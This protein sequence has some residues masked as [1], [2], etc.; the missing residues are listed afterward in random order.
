M[1]LEINHSYVSNRAAIFHFEK[2]AVRL[3]Y[4]EFGT[5]RRA[6]LLNF[7]GASLVIFSR[8]HSQKNRN[9]AIKKNEIAGAGRVGAFGQDTVQ[10]C[11][12]PAL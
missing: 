7:A 4:P 9:S 5:F 12:Y 2:C 8:E 10:S 3:E 6:D 1:S 11:T